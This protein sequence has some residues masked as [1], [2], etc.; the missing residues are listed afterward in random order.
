MGLLNNA[1]GGLAGV[2]T[3]H[4]VND[5]V[6][7]QLRGHHRRQDVL[8]QV[9]DEAVRHLT[10]LQGLA[11]R[12]HSTAGVVT[13]NHHNGGL[14]LINRVLQRTERGILQDVAG[15]THHERV[16][17]AQIKNNLCREARV[18]A[19]ENRGERELTRCQ[20]GTANRVL[21]GV[22][23]AALNKTAV[24]VLQTLPCFCG[25][26]LDASH[27]M[28]LSGQIQI[29]RAVGASESANGYV[30]LQ[31]LALKL[32]SLPGASR[33]KNLPQICLKYAKNS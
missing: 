22:L 12:S 1:D 18:T 16:A 13:E 4:V 3:H 30:G 10:G 6:L 17:Q 28:L 8:H 33:R 29:T 32:S 23:V 15:G 11:G 20:V 31:A 2:L 14:K 25:S 26:R 9:T 19:T 27:V 7:R 5:R 21:V 24:T